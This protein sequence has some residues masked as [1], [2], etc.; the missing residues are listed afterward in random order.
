MNRTPWIAVAIAHAIALMIVVAF[1]PSAHGQFGLSSK[2]PVIIRDATVLVD[3]EMVENCDVLVRGKR[4]RAVGPDLVAPDGAI[5]IDAAGKFVMPTMIDLETRVGIATSARSQA[6]RHLALDAVDP[7]G[8][9]PWQEALQSGVAYA[10]L[11]GQAQAGAGGRGRGLM[12]PAKDGVPLADLE[13]EN[14]DAVHVRLGAGAGPI[15][16]RNELIGFRKY[17]A[18]AK[19]YQESWEK[20]REDLAKYEKDLAEYAKKAGKGKK[21]G[22]AAAGKNSSKRPSRSGPPRPKTTPKPAPKKKA[23]SPRLLRGFNFGPPIPGVEVCEDEDCDIVGLHEEGDHEGE[24]GDEHEGHDHP[25]RDPETGMPIYRDPAV[26]A[27]FEDPA[28]LSPRLTHLDD[29]TEPHLT[30]RERP[31][32][33][34]SSLRRTSTCPHCGSGDPLAPEHVA[35]LQ[36]FPNDAFAEIGDR[37]A[38]EYLAALGLSDEGGEAPHDDDHGDDDHDDDDHGDEDHDDED[39][40]EDHEAEFAFGSFDE[41]KGAP[42]AK[43]GSSKGKGKSKG[44]APK[45]PKMPA[46]NPDLEQIVRILKGEIGVRIEI[47][48][49]EDILELLEIIEEY[50]MRAALVGASEGRFVAKQIAESGLTV[51]VDASPVTPAQEPSVGGTGFVPPRF[52]RGGFVRPN[53]RRANSGYKLPVQGLQSADNAAK[54]A[55]AGVPIAITSGGAESSTLLDRAAYA[56]SQGMDE[57]VALQA[58]TVNAAKLMGLDKVGRLREGYAASLVV[59]DGNPFHATSSVERVYRDGEVVFKK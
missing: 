9:D 34:A 31:S 50:P 1:A 25:T 35:H 40:D 27:I 53:F 49:A 19:K 20:Y 6:P 58:I 46:L 57:K 4:I 54:L 24:H 2:P 48:R 3:G 33:K 7:Y 21:G 11:A 14:S 42:A 44:G 18:A 43:G 59:F 30:W 12:M 36:P 15:A 41:K 16:R 52:G 39:H 32:V 38:A 56:V 13:I 51:L 17:V 23:Q 22:K 5:E 10:Y 26:V 37:L 8:L 55:A 28:E 29:G 47:H 45:Q